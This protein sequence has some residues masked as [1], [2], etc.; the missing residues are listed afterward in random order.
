[1]TK[2]S[3][4]IN[5]SIC[6]A[7][8]VK[9]ST[10]ESYENIVIN[11]A[12]LL[13]DSENL[14]V[15]N[16]YPVTLNIS[17]VIDLKG[18]YSASVHNGSYTLKPGPAPSVQTVLL[19]NGSLR[20][21]PG[22]QE[23]LKQYL[24]I[25]VNGSVYCPE[26]VSGALA[27][28][29]VNGRVFCYPDHAILLENSFTPDAYFPRLAKRDALYF[30]PKRLL[31]TNPK[32]DLTLLRE[33][34]VHFLCPKLFVHESKLEDALELLEG[35]DTKI[36]VLKDGCVFLDDDAT[37]DANLIRKYGTILYIDGDLTLNEKSTPYI[38]QLVSPFINGDV[39]LLPDQVDAF[40]ETDPTYDQLNIVS[41][42]VFCD[43]I[44]FTVDSALL[45]ISPGGISVEDSVDITI[46]P[47]L[48]SQEILDFLRFSDCVNI[49]CTKEQLSAVNSVAE[50]CINISPS[51]DSDSSAKEIPEKIK[52]EARNC[53]INAMTYTL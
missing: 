29:Q 23:I 27:N 3:L 9:E 48:S 24:G 22:T 20:V 10:L 31:F 25:T 32:L 49:Y 37:L 6:D 14:A 35:E 26:S 21:Y 28:A 17:K 40:L 50:D 19:V 36:Q 43:R 4:I 30:V 7:R 41:G 1:M 16:R 15:L 44:G 8:N 46:S 18:D 39:S 45:A 52:D 42:K 51:S 33:K 11:T 5:C 2:K 12:L 13:A 34:N 47:E 53:T 38:S